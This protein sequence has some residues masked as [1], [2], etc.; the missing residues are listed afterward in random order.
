VA[1]TR[2]FPRRTLEQVLRLPL[3]LR[4]HNGGN[5]WA[6]DQVA[7]A[8]GIGAKSGNFFYITTASRD[9][10]LTEGT[11]DTAEIKLT[12][13]GRRA[14]YPQS[15]S[16]EAE[17]LREAFLSV[18]VFRR[19]LQHYGGNNLP[20]PKFLANTLHQTFGVAPEFHEEFTDI[21]TKNCRFLGIGPHTEG[22]TVYTKT[23]GGRVAAT[24]SGESSTIT[25]AAPEDGSDA[26]VLFVIMPFVERE[27]RHETGFFQEVLDELFIPAGRDAGFRVTT[28]RRQGSDVIQSTQIWCSP[29]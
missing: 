5:P 10:G 9:Y 7:K 15:T 6:P 1:E 2:T 26:P 12:D 25:V 17:A 28:A 13:L 21:F 22:A 16:E 24:G 3:A 29:T 8:L 18:D 19:V 23:G 11:R 4:E 14:V 20:D 27:D